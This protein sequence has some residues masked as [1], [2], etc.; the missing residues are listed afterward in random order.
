MQVITAR[1]SVIRSIGGGIV[2]CHTRGYNTASDGENC[3]NVS[4][5]LSLTE[6]RTQVTMTS[7]Y[8]RK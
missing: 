4:D 6:D 1:S 8:Q 5:S 7:H 2:V 3:S